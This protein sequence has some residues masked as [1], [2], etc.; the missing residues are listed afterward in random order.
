MGVG[1][2]A[3]SMVFAGRAQDR[4]GPR[5]VATI[6]GALCGVGLIVASFGTPRTTSPDR[7]GIRAAHGIGIGLGYAA[8]TPAAVKW[9]PPSRKGFITGLVVA[10]FGL[11]SVYIA[12]LTKVLLEPR[13]TGTFRILGIA[14]LVVTVALAQL[15]ANPPGGLPPWETWSG[16]PA[17]CRTA[18]TRVRLARDAA[19][20]A[21][22]AAV[23]DVRILG[24]RRLMIIGH[25]AKIAAPR[26]PISTWGSCSSRCSLGQCTGR[27]AAGIAADRIGGVRTMLVVFVVQAAMMGA[28]AFSNTAGISCRSRP[29]SG[30]ATE[31]TSRCSRPRRQALRHEAPWRELRTRV[32]RM[33]SRRRLRLHDRRVDRGQHRRYG[34]AYGIAAAL[35]VVAASLTFATKPPAPRKAAVAGDE[36]LRIAA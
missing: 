11:A 35:C 21:V 17:R 1:V 27:V 4:F 16:R 7:S 13:V 12:P 8:A 30:S 18:A 2:F 3:L 14:F 29:P 6:G 5:I 32:H 36:G 26:W 15:L 31:R 20:P 23:A 34:L 28:L 9:F 10:G 24:V 25:M 33:G 22:R 19:H